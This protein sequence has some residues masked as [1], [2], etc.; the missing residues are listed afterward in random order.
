[1]RS[2]QVEDDGMDARSA[3]PAEDGASR[4][5][6]EPPPNSSH[7]PRPREDAAPRHNSP[8]PARSSTSHEGHEEESIEQYMAR[9][10]ERVRGMS[11]AERAGPSQPEPE[12]GDRVAAPLQTAIEPPPPP[13]QPVQFVPRP[14]PSQLTTNMSAMRD[15]ANLNARSAIDAHSRQQL[16]GAR[17]GKLIV[18]AISLLC[19]AVMFSFEWSSGI[20]HY[21]SLAGLVVAAAWIVQYVVITKRIRSKTDVPVEESS[22]AEAVPPAGLAE[23]SDSESLPEGPGSEGQVGTTA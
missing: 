8:A 2:P 3:S 22:P 13:P 19:T 4:R 17:S 21:G 15:L 1:M 20:T 23:G 6:Q 16:A 5:P 7:S 18:A 12:V 9:L 11:D 10:M 14:I